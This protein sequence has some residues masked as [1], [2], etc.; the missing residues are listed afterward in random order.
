MMNC[1]NIGLVF[2]G[3][4]LMWHVEGKSQATYY[5]TK[6]KLSKEDFVITV[7]IEVESDQIFIRIQ[8]RGRQY[9]FKLDTGASQGVLYDDVQIKG[10]KETGSIKSTDAVGHTREV[11][12]VELPSFQIEMLTVSGY[13]MQRMHRRFP[14]K[15]EDGIIGFALFNGGV[16]AKIDTHKGQI[17]LTD[18][19][20]LFSKEKGEIVKYRMINHV[21]YINVSPFE[22]LEV[23]ARFDTGSPRLFEIDSDRYAQIDKTISLKSSKEVGQTFGSRFGGHF[24]RENPDTITFLSLQRLMWG[25]YSFRDVHCSTLKGKTHV[26]AQILD[27][28]SIIIDPFRKR[29]IFQPYNNATSCVVK[30]SQKQDV[31]IVEKDGKAML[32]MVMEK[33]KAWLDGFRQ[34]YTIEKVN[35]KPLNFG[36]FCNYRWVLNQKYSFTLRSPKRKETIVTAFW[37]LQYNK[38]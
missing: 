34:G 36:E 29:L 31:A 4:M 37:P 8:I 32:G 5:D 25:N 28:G 14:K 18:D 7:P 24:G 20:K 2:L 33:S 17:T 10:L 3:L 21:P 38:K 15:G 23:E 30:N 27:Y 16:A 6:F 22:G 1:R 9:R 26:G 19:K 12:T 11:M 35:G 13:K